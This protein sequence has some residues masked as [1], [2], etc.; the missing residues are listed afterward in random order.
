M[1]LDANR[2]KAN[3]GQGLGVALTPVGAGLLAKAL[4]QSN[5]Q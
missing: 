5:Q 3:D 1:D 4:G 2:Y